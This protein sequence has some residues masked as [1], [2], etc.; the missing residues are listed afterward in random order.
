MKYIIVFLLLSSTLFS[1]LIESNEGNS[2]IINYEDTEFFHENQVV[3]FSYKEDD[4]GQFHRPSVPND[5]ISNLKSVNDV[6]LLEKNE[7]GF[8]MLGRNGELK[9]FEITGLEPNKQYRIDFIDKKNGKFIYIGNIRSSTNA[10]EPK[11]TP[12]ALRITNRID[13]KVEFDWTQP[14]AADGSIL[15]VSKDRLPQLP[16]D[17]T[18]Y[19]ANNEYGTNYTVIDG[20]TYTVFRGNKNDEPVVI[21]N[22]E[23]DGVYYFQVL[24]YN[25]DR[26]NFN[27]NTTATPT[28]TFVYNKGNIQ[29]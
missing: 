3:F 25:G 20:I 8:Y 7:E 15:I 27:Y 24:S 9:R 29:E 14:E 11:E 5:D 17:G 21:E 23:E 16:K 19:E 18:E 1:H 13:D 6:S 26:F 2:I 28:N 12:T 10:L 4:S 22:L